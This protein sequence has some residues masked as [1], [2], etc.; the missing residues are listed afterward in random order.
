MKHKQSAMEQR[1]RITLD[2]L[3][4]MGANPNNHN[5][6]TYSKRRTFLSS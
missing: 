6:S 3:A 2:N 5:P 1:T 4:P